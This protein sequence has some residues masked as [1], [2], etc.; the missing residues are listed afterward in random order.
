MTTSK[1]IRLLRKKFLKIF[2]FLILIRLGLYIPVPGVDLDIFAQTE[3]TNSFLGLIKNV[4]GSSFFG[5]G[6]LGITPY[7]NASIVIQLLTPVIP[8]LERLQKEEGELGR[9]QIKRYTRYL[10]L[11]LALVQSTGIAIFLVKPIVFN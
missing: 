6:S 7:I 8:S 4:I 11:G 5:I 9:K 1:T 3:S 2:G 10:A